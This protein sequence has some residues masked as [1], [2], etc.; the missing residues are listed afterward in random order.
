M[1][2]FILFSRKGD[3]KQK[4]PPIGFFFM[5]SDSLKLKAT[6]S[7]HFLGLSENL[8]DRTTIMYLDTT[9]HI[10]VW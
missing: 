2:T 8:R 9:P 7:I 5:L 3:Y 10:I 6:S 4:I 1:Y